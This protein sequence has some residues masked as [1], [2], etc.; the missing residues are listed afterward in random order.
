[1]D[2]GILTGIMQGRQSAHNKLLFFRALL[3]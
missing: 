2:R 3:F 1:M